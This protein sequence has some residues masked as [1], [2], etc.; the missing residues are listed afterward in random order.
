[1]LFYFIFSFFLF[2]VLFLCLFLFLRLSSSL[3]R[4]TF[5]SLSTRFLFSFA[6]FVNVRILFY[7]LCAAV[8]LTVFIYSWFVY[9]MLIQAL[10]LIWWQ[11]LMRVSERERERERHI[12]WDQNHNIYVVLHKWRHEIIEKT[13]A[14]RAMRVWLTVY[15]TNITKF[16]AIVTHKCL[17]AIIN[18]FALTCSHLKCSFKLIDQLMKNVRVCVC[19]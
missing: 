1:M 19:C 2:L 16:S 7:F 11:N 18:Y 3:Q 9:E 4:A 6:T 15:R 5:D 14:H 12:Y 17:R 8:S 10:V 13:W